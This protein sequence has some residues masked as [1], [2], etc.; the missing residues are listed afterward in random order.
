MTF[1]SGESQVIVC[2]PAVNIIGV[3]LS[4]L[5]VSLLKS[6][7]RDLLIVPLPKYDSVHQSELF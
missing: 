6:N 3:P 4:L 7:H 1:Q 2:D 5:L